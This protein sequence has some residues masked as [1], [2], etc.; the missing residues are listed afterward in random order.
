MKTVSIGRVNG[1]AEVGL[2]IHQETPSTRPP[3][4]RH[5]LLSRALIRALLLP[6]LL[7]TPSPTSKIGWLVSKMTQSMHNLVPKILADLVQLVRLLSQVRQTYRRLEIQ[8]HPPHQSPRHEMRH[9]PGVVNAILPSTY[10]LSSSLASNPLHR[11][12]SNV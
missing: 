11:R 9:N 12:F 5:R 1:S 10:L 4:L 3:S 2:R 8:G 6:S 7:M